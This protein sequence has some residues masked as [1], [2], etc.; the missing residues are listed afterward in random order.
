MNLYFFINRMA[1][2]LLLL[3]CCLSCQKDGLDENIRIE[4]KL[5]TGQ[6]AEAV[7]K[8]IEHSKTVDRVTIENSVGSIL[9]LDKLNESL[10]SSSFF[11]DDIGFVE[12]DDF[13][14]KVYFA[15]GIVIESDPTA[16][17]ENLNLEANRVNLG[18]SDHEFL[19]FFSDNEIGS[20]VHLEAE[21]TYQISN[22]GLDSLIS[23][24]VCQMMQLNSL[25]ESLASANPN[26]QI[27]RLDCDLDGQSN[28]VECDYGS[29]P[30]DSDDIAIPSSNPFEDP[31][32]IPNIDLSNRLICYI[33]KPFEN[34]EQYVQ[35]AENENNL[36]PP[37]IRLGRL[38]NDIRFSENFQLQVILERISKENFDSST[39]ILEASNFKSQSDEEILVSGFFQVIR[40]DTVIIRLDLKNSTF[41]EVEDLLCDPEFQNSESND[42]RCSDCLEAFKTEGKV[43][44]SRPEYWR[45]Y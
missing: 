13:V 10:Y 9:E 45:D 18:E 12:E 7:L 40:P 23:E 22:F 19:I 24:D 33:T 8:I 17:T 25:C 4:A 15:N 28:A 37:V 27:A 41:I 35:I 39:N 34:L 26:L 5:R 30:F 16:S 44:F 20:H 42:I 38:S 32:L 2:L 3:F 6:P 11:M 21:Y 14:M 29:N 1:I 36:I 43:S 31:D